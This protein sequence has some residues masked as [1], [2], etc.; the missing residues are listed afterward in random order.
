MGLMKLGFEA[1]PGKIYYAVIRKDV[2]EASAEGSPEA[3]FRARRKKQDKCRG[4]K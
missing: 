1:A 2:P 4:H 3:R